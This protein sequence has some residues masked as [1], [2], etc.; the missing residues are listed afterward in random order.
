MW[1][2]VADWLEWLELWLFELGLGLLW[3]YAED[4]GFHCVVCK[5]FI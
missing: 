2:F 4:C 1:A 3:G 5:Y